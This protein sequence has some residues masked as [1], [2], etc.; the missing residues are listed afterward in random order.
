MKYLVSLLAAFLSL[1]LMAADMPE[2]DGKMNIRKPRCV[3]PQESVLKIGVE[4]GWP[5]ARVFKDQWLHATVL[6]W[7][8]IENGQIVQVIF[9]EYLITKNNYTFI[10]RCVRDGTEYNIYIARLTPI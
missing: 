9:S 5:P 7:S 8:D 4:L 6:E 2:G 1:C 3:G 10:K